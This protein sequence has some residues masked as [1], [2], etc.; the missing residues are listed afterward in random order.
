MHG[1]PVLAADTEPYALPPV[2]AK[3]TD[4]QA[5]PHLRESLDFV[6]GPEESD[7]GRYLDP[8]CSGVPSLMLTESSMLSN[9]SREVFR[10]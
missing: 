7:A 4:T 2:C 9:T 5:P 10:P 6:L 8:R 1:V 3:R